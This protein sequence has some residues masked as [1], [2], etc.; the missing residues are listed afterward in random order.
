MLLS[1]LGAG[2]R[3]RTPAG[4]GG[5]VALSELDSVIA[6]FSNGPG[7]LRDF[8]DSTDLFQDA[9]ITATAVSG[10]PV[11]RA[12]NQSTGAGAGSHVLNEVTTS[13]KPQWIE[14]KGVTSNINNNAIRLDD[15]FVTLTG[16]RFDSLTTVFAVKASISTAFITSRIIQNQSS[17]YNVSFIRVGDGTFQV[18]PYLSQT[19]GNTTITGDANDIFVIMTQWMPGNILDVYVNNV[20]V[21]SP[22]LAAVSWLAG[23]TATMNMGFAYAQDITQEFLMGMSIVPG[24]MDSDQRQTFCDYFQQ[25]AGIL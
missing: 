8:R 6:S 9:G 14:G 5:V 19:L 11:G 12:I 7:F 2:A 10:D 18:Q 4:G 15:N 1:G 23:Q 21:A 3:R 13:V 20:L 16:V 25:N 17:Y 24:I 22:S